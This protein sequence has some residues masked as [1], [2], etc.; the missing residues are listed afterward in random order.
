MKKFL[1]SLYTGLLFLIHSVSAQSLS[2]MVVSPAGSFNSNGGYSLSQTVGEMT[3][4]Q[5]FT[6]VSAILTQGFQQPAATGVG[7][8]ELQNELYK[9]DVFPNP[10][11]GNFHVD[12]TVAKAVKMRVRVID[13]LGKLVLNIPEQSIEGNHRQVLDLSAKS[14]GVYMLQLSLFDETGKQIFR[15]ARQLQLIK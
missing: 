9:M 14:N 2:P 10:G 12:I 6:T 13:V 8:S 4:V 11:P 5:T 1:Y 3:M 15:Q 7:V